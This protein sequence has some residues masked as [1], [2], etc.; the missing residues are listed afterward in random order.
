[1][2]ENQ[3]T[4]LE[5]AQALV[6]GDR[7]AYYDHPLDNFTRI[8]KMWSVILGIEVSYRDVALCMDAVKISREVHRP[9]RDN[10][11]DGPGYWLALDMAIAEEER[12]NNERS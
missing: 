3:P 7:N 9:K 5:E 4:V 11:V 10:R 1:M 2:T 12:R 6:T 8:A